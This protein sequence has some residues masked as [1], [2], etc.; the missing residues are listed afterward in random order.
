MTT[1]RAERID[2]LSLNNEAEGLQER[3]RTCTI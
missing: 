3:E 1:E 2:K